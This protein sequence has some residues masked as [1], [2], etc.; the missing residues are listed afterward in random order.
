MAI[1]SNKFNLPYNRQDPTV[2]F[3][4]RERLTPGEGGYLIDQEAPPSPTGTAI[5]PVTQTLPVTLPATPVAVATDT[6]SL[7]PLLVV[8]IIAYFVLKG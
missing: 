6:S 1:I 5:V 4:P 7:L 2:R 3:D 8:G